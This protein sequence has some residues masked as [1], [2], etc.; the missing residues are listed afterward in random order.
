M[1]PEANFLVSLVG[2]LSVASFGFGAPLSELSALVARSPDTDAFE[3][4]MCVHTIQN[5]EGVLPGCHQILARL[6]AQ[7]KDKVSRPKTIF[8]ADALPD[9]L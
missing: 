1:K 6:M 9:Y 5:G 7:G 4:S 3:T 8:Q 2:V